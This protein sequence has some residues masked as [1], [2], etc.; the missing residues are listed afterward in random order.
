[1][2]RNEN[3]GVRKQSRSSTAPN[4]DV[5]EPWISNYPPLHDWLMK[6]EARCDW[7]LRY[8]KGRQGFMLEC[9]RLPGS[10]PFIVQVFTQSMGWDVFTPSGDRSVDATLAD[11]AERIY[12][13][14]TE[15]CHTCLGVG[16]IRDGETQELRK[17]LDCN[18]AGKVGA[19]P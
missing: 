2:A 1:M 18:G 8:G 3:P 9:W 17:C 13:G 16:Q 6:N 10:M 12:P 15:E 7:Q 11:L 19:K 14:A 5:D 4:K